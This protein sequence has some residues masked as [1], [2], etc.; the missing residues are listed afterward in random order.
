MKFKKINLGISGCMGR[1]GQQIIK[2]ARL[3]NN[4]KI[5]AL[6]EARI[7][8]K[9][10]NGIQINLNEEKSFKKTNL[11]IDFTVPKCTFQILEIALK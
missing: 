4:F 11:I 8:K 7:I 6:T 5:I 2:S 1:M 3:D 10:I 9:K